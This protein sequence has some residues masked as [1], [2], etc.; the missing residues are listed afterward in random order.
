[1]GHI[2][3]SPV[4]SGPASVRE[5]RQRPVLCPE[6]ISKTILAMVMKFCRWIDLIMGEYM[7]MNLTLVC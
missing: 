6:H 7:P 3:G 5:G 2:M 4:V 1:M